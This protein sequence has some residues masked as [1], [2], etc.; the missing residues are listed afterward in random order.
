[1]HHDNHEEHSN[2]PLNNHHDNETEAGPPEY[3]QNYTFNT[4]TLHKT[5]MPTMCTS[6]NLQNIHTNR[7]DAN[8]SSKW[9]MDPKELRG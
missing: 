9:Q 6:H 4:H 1:M 3:I 2:R 7:K 5:T 8:P